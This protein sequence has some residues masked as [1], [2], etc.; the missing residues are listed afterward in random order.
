MDPLMEEDDLE[1][2]SKLVR[3]SNWNISP[4][5][6]RLRNIV[7]GVKSEEY[8]MAYVHF[9]SLSD[10]IASAISDPSHLLRIAV[11]SEILRL[12]IVTACLGRSWDAECEEQVVDIESD[13]E[14]WKHQ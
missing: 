9:C 10:L 14:E 2:L 7:S 12:L 13:D 11:R 1:Y 3:S 5:G 6:I 8:G 4:V